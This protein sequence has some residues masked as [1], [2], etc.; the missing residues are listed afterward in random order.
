MKENET[1]WT[2]REFT[3]QSALAVLAAVPIT[4]S[5]AGCGD[6]DTPSTPSPMTPSASTPAPA[7]DVQGVV[8][9]NHGHVAT[10]KA[11][12]LTAGNAVSLDITGN[13]NHPHTVELSAS[14]IGQ[15]AMGA[16]VQKN[17]TNNAGHAHTVTFN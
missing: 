8:A 9:N 1:Q 5:S 4:I 10:I 13:A 11:A 7:G 2:R 16:R 3:L 6:G 17:S 14:E 15:I 12:Q